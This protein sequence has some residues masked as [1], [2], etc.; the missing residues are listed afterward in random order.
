MI[1]VPLVSLDPSTPTFTVLED[2]LLKEV[3]RLN[4]KITRLEIELSNL[5]WEQSPDRMGG[6]YSPDEIANANAWK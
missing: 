2:K 5:R 6:Q 1:G 3:I 4:K